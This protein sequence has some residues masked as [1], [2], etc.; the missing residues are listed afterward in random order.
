MRYFTFCQI[1]MY[2]FVQREYCEL[3][4]NVNDDDIIAYI[5]M[6]WKTRSLA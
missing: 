1:I 6:R 2:A 4:A 3:M 5:N